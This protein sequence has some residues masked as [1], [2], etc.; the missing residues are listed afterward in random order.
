MTLGRACW[1]ANARNLLR[2][3]LL[4]VK[5]IRIFFPL[6]GAHGILPV[7]ARRGGSTSSGAPW[8]VCGDW[9]PGRRYELWAEYHI[10]HA[11]PEA[12]AG[13]W[14]QRHQLVMYAKTTSLLC[15]VC[16]FCTFLYVG[17]MHVRPMLHVTLSASS[18]RCHS[19]CLVAQSLIC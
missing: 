4:P 9:L 18:N 12:M 5:R 11:L 1:L 10:R 14:W 17:W 19:C 7:R 2:L 13:W 8:D 16:L 15:F 6:P 3:L